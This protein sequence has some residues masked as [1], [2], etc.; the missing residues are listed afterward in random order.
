MGF[1]NPV[2][3][4]GAPLSGQP[5][6]AYGVAGQALSAGQVL[7]LPSVQNATTKPNVAGNL[8]YDLSALATSGGGTTF[9][10]LLVTVFCF[11]AGGT[12]AV[13]QEDWIIP[14]S[15]TGTQRIRGSGPV[16]GTLLQVQVKN[17]DSVGCTLAQFDLFVSS[18]PQTGS[19]W[20]SS[21]Q[22]PAPGFLVPTAGSGFDNCL[23]AVNNVTVAAS[24][25]RTYLLGLFAGNVYIRASATGT[26]DDTKVVFTVRAEEDS[27]AFNTLLS[28]KS[29]AGLEISRSVIF[30]R[31]VCE[32]DVFNNDAVN[33]AT[34][35]FIAAAQPIA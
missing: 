5:V 10:F 21:A 23:G 18:R 20:R 29:G 9:P 12:F 6:Q 17:L 8:C 26:A 15:A 16:R 25:S 22:A 13:S 7:S 24:T 27:S 32:L 34:V 35:F 1:D 19:D 31:A 14:M 2:I 3:V 28:S 33:A 4:T 30:P 11:D